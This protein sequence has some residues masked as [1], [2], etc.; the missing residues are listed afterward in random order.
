MCNTLGVFLNLY[1]AVNYGISMI[2]RIN[3]ILTGCRKMRT[4]LILLG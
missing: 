1:G 3:I 2:I 4:S